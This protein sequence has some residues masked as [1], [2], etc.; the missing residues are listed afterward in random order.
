MINCKSKIYTDIEIAIMRVA[1]D[2]DALKDLEDYRNNKDVVKAAIKSLPQAFSYASEELRDDEEIFLAAISHRDFRAGYG[3]DIFKHA[4]ERLRSDKGV[5]LQ[6]VEKDG[7]CLEF[8]PDELKAD[9][10]IVLKALEGYDQEFVLQYA[11]DELK[12]DKEVASK[13]WSLK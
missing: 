1:H 4:S 11:S 9:K 6:V 3:G 10:E 2:G 5:V 7:W 8:A 13:A 12:A